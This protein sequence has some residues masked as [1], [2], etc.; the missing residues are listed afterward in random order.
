MRG[1][2]MM[3]ALSIDRF[4]PVE[5]LCLARESDPRAAPGELLI[6]VVSTAINPVDDKTRNGDIGTSA[7]QLPFTLGWELAGVVVDD[8]TG[9]FTPGDRVV[10]MSHQLSTGRGTWADLVALPV[11]DVALAPSSVGLVEAGTLP[12]PGSTALQVLD[13]LGLQADSRLLV[14]G[15]A[16]AVGRI[17]VQVAADRGVHVDG[18]VSRPSQ[19]SEVASLGAVTVVTGV[20]DLP[21]RSYDGVFDTYGAN[22]S[23]AIRDG[24]RYATIATQAG[25]APDLTDRNVTSELRQVRTDGDTLRRLVGLVDS[26]V[27][28]PRVDS[29]FSVEDAVRAHQRFAVGG[30]E[31]KIALVF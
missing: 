24:G 5:D 30:L 14:T 13:W 27:I 3:R 11:E 7:P 23:E 10:G 15:A 26:G 22:A 17:A 16:G 2:S 6:R 20:E 4:G 8:P 29:V 9:L 28:T 1:V 12:L 21:A 31:G 25:P 19:I 18:V